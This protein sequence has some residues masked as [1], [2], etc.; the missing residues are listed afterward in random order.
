MNFENSTLKPQKGGIPGLLLTG[1]AA[2]IRTSLLRLTACD[3]HLPSR[4][5]EKGKCRL[6]CEMLSCAHSQ[7]RT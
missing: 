5:T 6:K 1:Y 7:M 4:G 2:I 3:T